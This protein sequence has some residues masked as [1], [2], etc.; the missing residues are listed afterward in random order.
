MSS[1]ATG[2]VLTDHDDIRKWAEA[3]KAQP[4]C[5]KGTERDDGTCLLR[6]DFPGYSGEDTLEAIPWERWFDGFDKR[7]LALLVEDKTPTGQVS[8]FNKLVSRETAK[9]REART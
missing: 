1:K 5:V 3:R 7:K 9:S 4:A 6:L 8:N 2:R